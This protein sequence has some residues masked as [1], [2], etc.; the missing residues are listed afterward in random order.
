M[1]K[2]TKTLMTGVVELYKKR[3]SPILVN[4]YLRASTYSCMCFVCVLVVLDVLTSAIAKK[5]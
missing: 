4:C 1:N 3:I 2:Q 5:K